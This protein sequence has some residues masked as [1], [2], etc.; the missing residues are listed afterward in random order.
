[1]ET[2]D[3]SSVTVVPL[4]DVEMIT[5]PTSAV[6][7]VDEDGKEI[8]RDVSMAWNESSV[9]CEEDQNLGD[10]VLCSKDLEQV[11]TF[12]WNTPV[13]TLEMDLLVETQK[14][15]EILLEQL[16][17]HEYLKKIKEA[18]RNSLT[19]DQTHD[20]SLLNQSNSL[21]N[22]QVEASQ[23]KIQLE[24]FPGDGSLTGLTIQKRRM[25]SALRLLRQLVPNL[26]PESQIRDVFESTAQY[27]IQL[28]HHPDLGD[29]KEIDREFLRKVL[30]L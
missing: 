12:P 15:E 1:M 19:F 10:F 5:I 9:V 14:Q 16:E 11:P 28:K 24:A 26:N 6:E 17:S 8:F 27:I 13:D 23:V 4:D 20:A 18:S 7:F 3:L 30:P 22:V 2:I 29:V 25:K 21:S